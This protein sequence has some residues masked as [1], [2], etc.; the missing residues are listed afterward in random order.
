M[1]IRS[2]LFLCLSLATWENCIAS[3]VLDA[4]LWV[5]KV[6]MEHMAAFSTN[7]ATTLPH[8]AMLSAEA[9]P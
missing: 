7:L 3:Y 2:K 9:L 6:P 8:M 4:L 5:L 1:A